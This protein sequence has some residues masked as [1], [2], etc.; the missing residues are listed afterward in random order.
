M[1]V[2]PGLIRRTHVEDII[3]VA[4]MGD[5]NKIMLPVRIE[6]Q[7]EDLNDRKFLSIPPYGKPQ[8][9]PMD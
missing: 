2:F 8:A 5:K 7:P 3:N 4:I 9:G 6:E 1:F